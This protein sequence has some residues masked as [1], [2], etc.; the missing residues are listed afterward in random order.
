LGGE[1]IIFSLGGDAMVIK[2]DDFRG[3][4]YTVTEAA[5]ALKVHPSAVRRMIATGQLK[6]HKPGGGSHYRLT[7]EAIIEYL[8][9]EPVKPKGESDGRKA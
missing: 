3:R 5:Q 2:V 9:G 4:I 8:T 6:A 7:G 1:G